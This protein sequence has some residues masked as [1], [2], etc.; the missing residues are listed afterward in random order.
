[1]FANSKKFVTPV[2]A[3]LI[4]CI[5]VEAT[6]LSQNTFIQSCVCQGLSSGDDV[7]VSQTICTAMSSIG[8]GCTTTSCHGTEY[9]TS[10]DGQACSVSVAEQAIFFEG[11]C[12]S[13]KG[14]S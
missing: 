12:G 13:S 4:A 9:P 5:A 14:T 8:F 3:L 7:K 6:P 2:V 11:A 1:M 10:F